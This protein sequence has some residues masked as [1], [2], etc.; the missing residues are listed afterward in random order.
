M[1][2]RSRPIPQDVSPAAATAAGAEIDARVQQLLASQL[3]VA[4]SRLRPDALLTEDLGVD[5]LAAI[6]LGMALEDEFDIVLDDDVL[7]DI[8]TYTD[9]LTAVH[10]RVDTRASPH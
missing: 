8:T 4:P 5:S 6:E 9:V 10:T 2:Q 1:F 7:A 3:D